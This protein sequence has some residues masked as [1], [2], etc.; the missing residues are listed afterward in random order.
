M[1][2]VGDEGNGF[3]EYKQRVVYSLL[4][5]AAR[6]GLKLL[7]PLGTM[8]TLLQMACFQEAR[9]RQG[10]RLD[11]I[12]D[13]FG[14]SLR[15]VST[16]HSRFRGDF[17]APERDVAFRRA[18]AAVVNHAPADLQRLRAAFPD[19]TE[20]ALGAALDDLLREGRI[21]KVG[22]QW[23]RNP[24][25]HEFL[26]TEVREKVDGLNRQMDVIAAAVWHRL[27]EASERP[28]QARTYVFDASDAD[29]RGA[30]DAVD[31]LIRERAIAA[32]RAAEGRREGARVGITFAAAPLGEEP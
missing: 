11:A 26:G 23:R 28:A 31:R 12:A 15:T 21:V 20:V 18:I 19:V 1:S 22:E 29:L 9:E 13:L 14:K 17:F 7:L 24:E 10:H 25:A 5:A 16:L 2:D 8:E 32:D 27:V 6:V 4:R 30:I 3:L